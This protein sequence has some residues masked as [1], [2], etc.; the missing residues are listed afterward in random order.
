MMQTP[1]Q[2]IGRRALSELET[3][4][5]APIPEYYEVWFRH[6]EGVSPELSDAINDRLSQ[7][8][9][10]S[11]HFLMGLYDKFCSK[12]DI[13]DNELARF[14]QNIDGQAGGLQDIAQSMVDSVGDFDAEL[15]ETAAVFDEGDAEKPD[16][17]RVLNALA[18]TASKAMDRNKSLEAELESASASITELRRSLNEVEKHAYTDFLTKLC[19][20]RRFVTALEDEI[21]NSIDKKAP[22]SLIVCDIDYFKKYNDTYGHQIGDQVLAMVAN[23]LKQNT[24]GKDLVARY[25]G[26]EFAIILPNTP[27]ESASGVAE[28]LRNFIGKRRIVTTNAKKDLGKVTMSF[29]VAEF[30]GEENWQSFFQAADD[31]L[32]DAKSTGRNKVVSR[33]SRSKRCA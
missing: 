32:Y 4:G 33:R 19:N 28:S 8:L 27:E 26:E 10:I 5:M 24:K 21:Q 29:G 23:V 7:D 6:I 13:R 17:R 22:L 25:G 2:E 12:D 31:A 20:R 11:T 16:I 1:L 15:K 3:I 9:P 30:D 14:I 18:V